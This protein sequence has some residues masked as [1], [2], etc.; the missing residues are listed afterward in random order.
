MAG[1]QL[2][3]ALGSAWQGANRADTSFRSRPLRQRC[4]QRAGGSHWRPQ[5][6]ALPESSGRRVPTSAVALGIPGFA[7]QA[8]P[9]A[10]VLMSK[11]LERSGRPWRRIMAALVAVR[12]ND[13]RSSV[14]SPPRPPRL[15]STSRLPV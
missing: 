1:A 10:P 2:D 15:P 4:G 8:T 9:D 7:I 14:V 6:G 11:A 5:A 3:S 13:L 12:L